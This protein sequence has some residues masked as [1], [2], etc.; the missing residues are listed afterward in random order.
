MEGNK[1]IEK[2]VGERG[3]C[4]ERGREHKM[5][6]SAIGVLSDGYCTMMQFIGQWLVRYRQIGLHSVCVFACV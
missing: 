1:K 2:K 5:E 4:R 6:S 3:R